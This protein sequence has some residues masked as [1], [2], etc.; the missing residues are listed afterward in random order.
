MQLAQFIENNAER[1]IEAWERLVVQ[2][3]ALDLDRSQLLDDLPSFVDDLVLALRDPA[4]HWPRLESA[5]SHGEHRMRFGIDIGALIEEIAVVG[6]AVIAVAREDDRSPTGDEILC[7]NRVIGRG[8]AS[9][10]T[11]YSAMRDRE[12]TH[13]A[14]E[15]FSFIAHE[16]RTPLQTARLAAAMLSASPSPRPDLLARLDRSLT[17]LS[18]L[19]DNALVQVRLAAAP[20]MRRE[21]LRVT[22]LV[23]AAWDGIAD[24]AELRGITVKRHVT[25]FELDADRRLLVSALANLL[26]NAVKFSRE[27]GRVVLRVIR[28][29]GRALFEVEDEC[30]GMPEDV[31]PRLFHPYVQA[32]ADRS[33][34]GLG[35]MIV[36]QAAEA[37]GGSVRVNNRP[38]EGCT[39]VLDVP[40]PDED[41]LDPGPE[42]GH[43]RTNTRRG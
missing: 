26:K 34:F 11:A 37:H 8:A 2:R 15:H 38:G 14:G 6:E 40:L 17:H 30:G 19:V 28:G 7:L 21:R 1:I 18:D 23:E 12:L 13:Q 39:F 31:P 27:G 41:G 43:R 35:L 22:D 42:S 10:A 32:H 24:H 33:G 4:G 5:R 25:E 36:K 9:S 20:T 16:L 29:E 3:L